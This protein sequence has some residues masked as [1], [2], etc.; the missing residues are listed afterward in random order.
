[1]KPATASSLPTPRL[2]AAPAPFSWQAS[3]VLLR[4]TPCPALRPY[5]KTL[6]VSREAACAGGAT[7]ELMLPSGTIQVVFRLSHPLRVFDTP[8]DTQGRLVAPALIGGA[9]G[10]AH[11]RDLSQ[12]IHSVG[13]QLMPGAGPVLLGVP[14]DLLSGRHT[15]L[16]DVWGAEAERV[17]QRLIELTADPQRQLD[18]FEAVLRQRLALARFQLGSVTHALD[19]LTRGVRVSE[20]AHDSGYSHKHFI[21]L[22]ERAVG[23]PP[24]LYTRVLRMAS[25]LPLLQ[26]DESLARIALRAGYSDQAHF[27]REF[28][29][30]SG[31]TPSAYLHLAPRP[32][33][34]VPLPPGAQGKFRS[35]S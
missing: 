12:P 10:Q 21:R 5:V 18:L 19:Q 6:W 30:L 32:G 24:K 35:R 8:S 2:A 33:H 26:G 1:M 14:A 16:T 29:A 9:R 22:F 31:L 15:A 25:A 34:H 20:V 13:A 23:L 4:R 28:R 17:R 7:R 27:S 11:V 3:R